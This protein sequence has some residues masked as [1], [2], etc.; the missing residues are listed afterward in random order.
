MP[1]NKKKE[2]EEYNQKTA[3]M[4]AEEWEI[5]QE[6]LEARKSLQDDAIKKLYSA[7]CLS[8]IKDYRKYIRLLRL[9]KYRRQ[10]DF[11]MTRRDKKKLDEQI[12]NIQENIEECEDFFDSDIFEM[13]T[14]VGDKNEIIR[15]IKAI[16]DGYDHV[17]ERGFA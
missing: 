13:C 10:N 5:R 15:R 9:Y 4:T 8:A 17:L 14:G 11:L 6:N 7:A 1:G 16:P 2:K 3:K 12:A